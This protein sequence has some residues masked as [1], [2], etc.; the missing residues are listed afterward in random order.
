MKIYRSAVMVALAGVTFGVMAAQ[1]DDKDNGIPGVLNA[2]QALRA[3]LATALNPGNVA[4]TPPFFFN[5]PAPQSQ[6]HF[7]L[8]T[9]LSAA[10]R[11]VKIDHIMFNGQIQV[12]NTFDVDPGITTINGAGAPSAGFSL[13]CQITVVNGSKR[14]IVGEATLLTFGSNGL[15]A[16]ASLPAQ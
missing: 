7:C 16:T 15:E 5:A 1:N 2:I 6:Q 4:F 9:N 13:R 3:D 8:V 10:K 11:T 12:T 14:D